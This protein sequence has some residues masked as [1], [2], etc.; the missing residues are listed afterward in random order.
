MPPSLHAGVAAATRIGILL[1][2]P[3]LS[4]V[5]SSGAPGRP[6]AAWDT[7]TAAAGGRTPPRRGPRS[8]RGERPMSPARR[9]SGA[10]ALVVSLSV[11][12]VPCVPASAQEAPPPPDTSPDGGR[13]AANS[14]ALAM[15]PP[16][17]GRRTSGRFLP[18]LGRN[19]VGV[20]S[21]ENL[22]AFVITAGATGLAAPFDDDVVRY[23]TP[24]RQAK[25][26]GDLGANIGKAYVIGPA[27]AVLFGAG[28][29]T[30][31]GRFRDASY[32][33][34]QATLVSAAYTT[35]LK[36]PTRR[37]R[38]DG[39]NRLSL[40]SGHTSNAFAW[41]TVAAHHYRW[42]LGVPS[43]AFATLMGIA[44]ME[45]NSH[46]VT[47]VVAAAG[48]GYICGR[49]VVRQAGEKRP[50]ATARVSL[51]PTLAASGRGAGLTLAIDF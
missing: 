17:D 10:I 2:G 22:K 15:R 30:A 50:G 8:F 41:A 36:Y 26:L 1:S 43:Y 23:F 35:A 32:D 16:D 47:D 3:T 25:W 6:A 19:L 14:S 12:V 49:T 18:N 46:H 24:D 42:Q 51:A 9:I 38:P 21:R 34:A 11:S 13:P 27:A 33:I 20:V 48:L 28:R 29:L 40:P 7:A 39:S 45:K 4:P 44:R 31:H 5:E 37:E